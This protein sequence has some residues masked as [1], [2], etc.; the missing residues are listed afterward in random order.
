M[1]LRTN[2]FVL[3]L[4][5][6][7]LV[8]CGDDA[9]VT[10]PNISIGADAGTGDDAG[11]APLEFALNC[12]GEFAD[13]VVR[14]RFWADPD[15]LGVSFYQQAQEA[16]ASGLPGEQIE[17]LLDDG[18]RLGATTCDDGTFQFPDATGDIGLMRLP[19][20]CTTAN[21]TSRFYQKVREGEVKVLTFGDSIPAFGP[22]P[23]FPE[24]LATLASPL[25][26]VEN[27]NVA[28]PGSTSDQWLPGTRHF[29]NR[30]EAHLDADVFVFSVGGNDLQEFANGFEQADFTEQLGKLNPLIDEIIANIRLIVGEIRSLSPDADIVWMLYPNYGTTTYWKEIAGPDFETVIENGLGNIL[31]RVRR[32]LAGE[33]GM[34]VVDILG[35]TKDLDL[36]EFLIDPLHLNDAGHKFYARELFVTLGGVIMNEPSEGLERRVGYIP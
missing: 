36:D 7:T 13:P 12:G 19:P 20:D 21:C 28:V 24:R 14:G 32:Q 9:G 31:S 10:E 22:R 17:L 27:T 30:I 11:D 3:S 6:F 26:D 18:T 35:A 16:A 2:L 29:T 23:W 25:A 8:A 5:L 33:A 4:S 34:H 15:D 1:K